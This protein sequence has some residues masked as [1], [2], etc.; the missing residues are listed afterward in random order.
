MHAFDRLLAWRSLAY[1]LLASLMTLGAVTL[2]D[3]S[4]SS[5][6]MRV[7]RL[8]ALGPALAAV[9]ATLAVTQARARG[10]LSALGALGVSPF[11]QE[12]GPMLASWL[13]G[14]LAIAVLLSPLSDPSSLFPSIATP[15]SW[16]FEGGKMIDAARGIRVDP[17]GSL[18]LVAGLP[19][20]GGRFVPTGMAAVLA[21][22]PHAVVTPVWL[23]ARTGWAARTVTI[24]FAVALTVVLLHAASA[25]Q[26]DPRWLVLGALPPGLQG[27]LGHLRPARP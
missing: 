14:G 11:R 13:V 25:E 27:A 20:T 22:G 7:A 4:G 8:C 21:I 1:T 23:S 26:I 16:S 2:T 3:E 18:A 9:G 12:L 17:D 19:A 15:A 10:E 5:W 24:G 6:A